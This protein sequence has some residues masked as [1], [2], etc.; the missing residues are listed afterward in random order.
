MIA[1]G[2]SEHRALPAEGSNVREHPI[3]VA[4]SC[5]EAIRALNPRDSTNFQKQL[6]VDLLSTMLSFGKDLA[7][8]AAPKRTDL[9]RL[10][11]FFISPVNPTRTCFPTLYIHTGE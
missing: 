6:R 7:E 4:R 10:P 11:A 5:D 8:S 9:H 3:G 1:G 2:L